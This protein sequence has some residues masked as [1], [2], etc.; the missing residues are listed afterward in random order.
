MRTDQRWRSIKQRYG[1]T[2]EQFDAVWTA[3]DGRCAICKDD[4][5][6]EPGLR[7][8]AA[9]DHCHVSGRVR[10]LLCQPCNRGLGHFRDRLDLLEAAVAYL[11]ATTDMAASSCSE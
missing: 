8:N 10:G 5:A 1:L 3:Q 2:R 11:R 4:I 6:Q 9:T 7:M